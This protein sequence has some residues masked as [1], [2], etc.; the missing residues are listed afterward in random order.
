MSKGSF[1]NAVKAYADKNRIEIE[2]HYQNKLQLN[3]INFSSYKEVFY[4]GGEVRDK[5]K[6]DFYNFT[7][8]MSIIEKVSSYENIKQFKYLSSLSVFGDIHEDVITL[9]SSRKPLDK[10][11]KTKNKF[12]IFIENLLDSTNFKIIS[13]FPASI[14]SFRG[15]SSVEKWEKFSASY[16]PRFLGFNGCLS[17]VMRSDL[18]DSIFNSSSS[19]I[20]SDSFSLKKKLNFPRLPLIFFKILSLINPNLSLKLRMVIRGINYHD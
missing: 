14:N 11:G 8:P 15:R 1:C 4:L 18:I 5:T 6:M 12:D 19:K 9:N 10:Y 20:L 2:L 3:D 13:I 16:L 17:Y 7:L